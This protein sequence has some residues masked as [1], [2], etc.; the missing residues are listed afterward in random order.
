[1][2]IVS[3][4]LFMMSW[5]LDRPWGQAQLL[6]G[7]P[8][9]RQMTVSAVTGDCTGLPRP[10]NYQDSEMPQA[11]VLGE[12]RAMSMHLNK[13]RLPRSCGRVEP[14][15]MEGWAGQLS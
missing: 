8:M 1:M 12:G 3:L 13:S 9:L 6:P 4:M 14:R 15:R 10:V 2:N 5:G 7:T 11:C